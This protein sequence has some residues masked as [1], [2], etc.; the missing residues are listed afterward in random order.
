MH[1]SEP[2]IPKRSGG[3]YFYL[4]KRAWNLMDFQTSTSAHLREPPSP[5]HQWEE[6]CNDIHGVSARRGRQTRGGRRIKSDPPLTF[7]GASRWPWRLACRSLKWF[8]SKFC[9]GALQIHC[10]GDTQGWLE[11]GRRDLGLPPASYIFLP[12]N[13]EMESREMSPTCWCNA[14]LCIQKSSHCFMWRASC[15]LS[16]GR[17]G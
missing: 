3:Y 4:G 13:F 16:H 2:S 7:R 6:A 10:F 11:R 8:F 17:D 14:A 12:F 15:S 5:P 9:G 1:Q